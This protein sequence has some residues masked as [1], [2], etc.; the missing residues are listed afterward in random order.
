MSQPYPTYLK[1]LEWN[2]P[3]IYSALYSRKKP[4]PL[5]AISNDVYFQGSVVGGMIKTGNRLWKLIT[6]RSTT[7]D[8]TLSFILTTSFDHAVHAHYDQ[9]LRRLWNHMLQIDHLWKRRN[10]PK[11]EQRFIEFLKS[12]LKGSKEATYPI[13]LIDYRSRKKQL[14]TSDQKV[15]HRHAIIRF[16]QATTVFWS[17]FLAK[18]KESIRIRQPLIPFLNDTSTLKDRALYQALKREGKWIRMEGLMGQEIPVFLFSK[19]DKFDFLSFKN[20]QKLKEW[21]RAYNENLTTL[22]PQLIILVLN[23]VAKVLHMQGNSSLTLKDIL[24]ELNK[25]GCKGFEEADPKHLDW[26]EKLAMGDKIF[27]NGIQL[28][29]GNELK[30]AKDQEEEHEDVHRVFELSEYPESVVK[31]ACNR[32]SL[33][34]DDRRRKDENEHW[35]IR[36]VETVQKIGKQNGLDHEGCCVVQEKLFPLLTTPDWQSTRPKLLKSEKH[37]ALV[38]ASHFFCISQWNVGIEKLSLK[39]L[40][41]DKDGVLKS[42]RLIKKVPPN[43]ND[44]EKSCLEIAGKNLHVLQF[45]MNVSKLKEHPVALYYQKV[46]CE[47]IEKGEVHLVGKPLPVGFRETY[48]NEHANQLCHDALRL[49]ESCVKSVIQILSKKRNKLY[50]Q[51]E[52]LTIE[53]SKRLIKFYIAS[54]TRSILFHG[55]KKQ[56]TQS[57]EREVPIANLKD[58]YKNQYEKMIEYNTAALHEK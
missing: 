33:L 22:S 26:R 48:Y 20:Q 42:T 15:N 34:I 47:T 57:Y 51:K 37:V 54:A 21:I 27:C 35:G 9:R 12:D 40:M 41:W 11:Q 31:I 53:V 39:H 16:H 1:S 36:L 14:L 28:T 7:I 3:E 2:L 56:V 25:L 52:K 8:K 44:W 13:Y 55:L 49:R 17:L 5:T 30:S 50:K 23:E 6:K 32:F 58:Y 24:F 43:Y 29:L 10:T 18:D 45:L 38:L 19:L 4:L 46:V